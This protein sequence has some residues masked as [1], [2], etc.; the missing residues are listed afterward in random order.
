[1]SN[2]AA[3]Q[4]KFSVIIPAFNAEKTIERALASVLGQSYPAYE[5][6]VVDD[7]STDNTYNLLQ[8]YGDQIRHIQKIGNT[9]SSVARN[10]G[11]D[12]ATG[13]YFA[14]L[15]ADDT[16][17]PDKLALVNT[18]LS[19]SPG[20]TLFFHP[21]TQ[22]N[23]TNKELPED[24]TVYKLP[25]IKLLPANRIATSCL[26]LR[27]DAA[28]RFEPT[29]RYTEDYDLCLRVGY[30]HKLY[31]IDIPLTQIYRGFT[32]KGGIS[33]NTWK[34]RRGEMWAYRRLVNLNPLFIFLLPFLW[35]SSIGKHAYKLVVK[36]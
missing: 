27:N 25:F 18:I 36:K 3:G 2:G 21:Y 29:M 8:N 15:D 16:W 10:T 22:E 33:G 17:H 26:I 35:M 31:F 7:A 4:I 32:T 12:A 19:A 1:M 20:L 13:D 24:I 30:K 34:M 6:I 28:F 14:F 23:I 5:I 9:G 11:M